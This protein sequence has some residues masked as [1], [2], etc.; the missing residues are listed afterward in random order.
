M[1]QYHGVIN[2]TFHHVNEDK[3]VDTFLVEQCDSSMIQLLFM[4]IRWEWFT[5]A[6]K[7]RDPSWKEMLF[8]IQV[9]VSTSLSNEGE[10]GIYSQL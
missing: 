2:Y 1:W 10:E 8:Q 5:I 7:Q 9:K 3:I 6:E 4:H